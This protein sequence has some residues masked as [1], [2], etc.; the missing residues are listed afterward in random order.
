MPQ[1]ES[2]EKPNVEKRIEFL[3]AGW[4]KGYRATLIVRECAR[5]FNTSESTAWRDFAKAQEELGKI[6]DEKKESL[7][8][9][10]I[11]LMDSLISQ[12]MSSENLSIEKKADAVVKAVKHR[13]DV[14]G[15]TG[16][17]ELSG[18]VENKVTLEGITNEQLAAVGDAYARAAERSGKLESDGVDATPRK[19]N[20]RR[21]V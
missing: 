7:I 3:I 1:S 4:I 21:A 10:S 20:R 18:K 13:D 17:I 8:G 5:Q 16:K 15:L 6:A 2:P 9:R 11:G 19:K 14:L 12:V